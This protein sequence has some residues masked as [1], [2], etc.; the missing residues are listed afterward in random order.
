MS[1]EIKNTHHDIIIHLNTNSQNKSNLYLRTYVNGSNNVHSP[2]YVWNDT[3]KGFK[4]NLKDFQVGDVITK[5]EIMQSGGTY[6][7]DTHE[8]IQVLLNGQI[9]NTEIIREPQEGFNILYADFDLDITETGEYDIQAVYVGNNALEMAR[10]EKK[11]FIIKE[12]TEPEDTP[13]SYRYK[14]NF[15]D[16]TTPKLKYNDGT[17]IP[18]K[19]T[20]GGQP[21]SNKLVQILVGDKMIASKTTNAKGIVNLINEGIS[22]GKVKIGAYFF[23]PLDSGAKNKGK[24]VKTSRWV[25]I[26]KIDSKL[27]DNFKADDKGEDK[28]FI[29]GSKYVVKL[30]AEGK[31]L[32]NA[33]LD[34]FVNGEKIPKTTNK[35]GKIAYVFKTDDTY[36]LKTVFAGTKSIDPVTLERTITI[37]D[38]KK[39]KDKK[40]DENAD[41]IDL[42]Q[43]DV[44]T[45]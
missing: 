10:T 3:I 30:T 14:L 1:Y 19:L 40:S 6:L 32:E 15:V 5:I 8:G 26:D 37:G 21:A 39:D 22:G 9:I 2:T 24:T 34:F 11:H 38:G 12:D 13:S 43:V 36:K 35:N 33:K 18:F 42:S 41:K 23:V 31:I 4:I 25:T 45:E 29:K 44:N 20:Y 16:K 27:T 7:W 17:I 28:N